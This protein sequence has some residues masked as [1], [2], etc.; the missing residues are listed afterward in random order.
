M[1]NPILLNVPEEF[2]TERLYIRMPRPGDGK[3]VHEAIC[4]SQEELKQWLSFAS[5]NQSVEDVEIITREAHSKFLLREHL[6]FF[7]FQKNTR[8][9]IATISLHNADWEVPKFEIGYWVDSRYSGQGYISEAVRGL[10]E[11]AFNQLG[12][13]RLTIRCDPRN[14]KSKAVAERAGF[15]LEGILKNDEWS[16][17]GTVLTDTCIYSK[18]REYAKE[19]ESD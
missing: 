2:F 5:K 6:R 18:I 11:F 10:T 19:I 14:V 4:A 9:F 8:T 17:D 13:N 15:Q 7:V 16:I 1:K 3:V 12:A